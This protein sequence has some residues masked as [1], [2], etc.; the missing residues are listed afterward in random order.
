LG[1][2]RKVGKIFKNLNRLYGK[3]DINAS[4]ELMKL[5]AVR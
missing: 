5:V 4:E 2:G 1:K 3:R